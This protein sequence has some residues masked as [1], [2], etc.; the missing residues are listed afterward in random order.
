MIS[1]IVAFDEKQVIGFEGWMPWDLKE[2]LALFKKYTL[3]KKIVMGKNTFLGLKKPLPHRYTYVVSRTLVD[4]IDPTQGCI[5]N[6]FKTL[7]EAYE[8]S[9][10]ELCICGGAAIYKEALP[11]VQKMYISHVHGIHQG[12]TFFPTYDPNQ[13]LLRE[14]HPY[15]GFDFCIYERVER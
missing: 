8:H 15:E 10:E 3:H 5:I 12:D 9:D 4:A 6:D 1:L 13:F 11:Y 7:L 14:R 2:D